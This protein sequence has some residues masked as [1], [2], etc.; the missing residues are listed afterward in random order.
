[1]FGRSSELAAITAFVERARIGGEALLL[2]G[3][4]GMLET[5]RAYGARLLAGA[6]EQDGAAV[7]LAGYALGVAEEA[8]AGLQ[9][10]EGSWPRPAG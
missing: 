1:M 5:L 10:S 8:A 2:L 4:Y 9:S 3:E 7:A 6:G